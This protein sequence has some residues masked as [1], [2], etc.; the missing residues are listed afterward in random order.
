MGI[1]GG[2]ALL[3]RDLHK[4][5]Y[6]TH[7]VYPDASID[8]GTNGLLV[9]KMESELIKAIKETNTRIVISMYPPTLQ[10]IDAIVNYLKRNNIS[11]AKSNGIIKRQ[12]FFKKHDVSGKNDIES[13]YENCSSKV[14]TT[15]YR[16]AVSGCY[17]PLVAPLFNNKFGDYFKVDSDVINFYDESLSRE[18]LIQMLRQ[19][20][21]A[22]RYC[23]QSTREPW[24]VVDRN[25]LRMSDWVHVDS[26]I[27]LKGEE[28]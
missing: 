10:Q 18:K 11:F 12:Y 3:C 20:M 15:V 8:L 22:C 1:W 25:K 19:P 9:M 28:K 16:G 7:E 26:K 17:F 24:S 5:I 4:Y 2:E 23:G 13:T 14:C 6:K 21:E 27:E